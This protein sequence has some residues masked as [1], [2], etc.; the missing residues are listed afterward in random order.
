[1]LEADS[2]LVSTYTH[3]NWVV[4]SLKERKI[5][6]KQCIGM[7]SRMPYIDLR[8]NQEGCVMIETVHKKVAGAT[9]REN[10]PSGNY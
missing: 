7:C 4:T 9:E 5:T 6:F 10:L 8:E 2:Y 1:M 3:G